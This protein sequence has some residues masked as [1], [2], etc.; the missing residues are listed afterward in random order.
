MKKAFTVILIIVLAAA[1]GGLIFLDRANEA[2]RRTNLENEEAVMLAEKEIEEKAAREEAERLAAEEAARAEAEAL[3]KAEEAA[4]AEAEAKAKAE[5]EARAKAEAEAAAAAAA[6]AQ[7]ISIRGD[8]Y[9]DVGEDV[10]TG[11]P[12][13]L[14]Q[15][16]QQNGIS[17]TVLDNTWDMSGTLSQM[18][19]AGISMDDINAYIAKHNE[20]NAA[21]KAL[22]YTDFRVRD[23]LSDVIRERDDLGAIPVIFMGFNGG[24]GRD[25][26]ELVEQI[27][28]MIDSYEQ[29]DK[30]LVVGYPP[31][32]WNDAASYRTAMEEAFGDHFLYISNNELSAIAMS[33]TG[34]S[35]IA[36][37]IF[38]KLSAM[39]YLQ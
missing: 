6:A 23:D 9:L 13:V 38:D 25:L 19:F 35:E 14:T 2:E 21:G 22:D 37:K 34:R 33:P 39:G 31:E 24:W 15:L 26:S 20:I 12:R 32:I 10:N 3:K 5:E 28:K 7:V 27:W 29:K 36:Q 16:F 17:K 8:N 18:A 1:L 30:Y 11:Y 4:K